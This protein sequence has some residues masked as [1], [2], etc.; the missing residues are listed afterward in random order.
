MEFS[1]VFITFLVRSRKTEITAVGI[2]RA[3]HSTSLCPQ[4]LAITSPTSG[5][6]SVGAVRSRTQTIE[7]V[8]S[9]LA[10]QGGTELTP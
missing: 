10:V 5:G 6:H 7:L 1:F 4:K 9:F 8:I 3:D 2:R